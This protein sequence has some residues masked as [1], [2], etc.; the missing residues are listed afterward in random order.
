VVLN[1]GAV[2]FGHFSLIDQ[3]DFEMTKKNL[4]ILVRKSVNIG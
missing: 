2:F 4:V 3:S 1:E